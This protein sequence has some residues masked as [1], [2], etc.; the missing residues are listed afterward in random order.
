MR[1]NKTE[2]NSHFEAVV[3]GKKA[4]ENISPNPEFP[5][6]VMANGNICSKKVLSRKRPILMVPS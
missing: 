2:R 3:A 1:K 5:M 4:K 6:H